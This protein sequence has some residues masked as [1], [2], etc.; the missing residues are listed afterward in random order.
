MNNFSI[1]GSR[2]FKYGSMSVAITALVIAAVVILNVIFSILASANGWFIDLTTESLY[3]LSDT[4]VELLGKTFDNINDERKAEGAEP[5]KV[6]IRFCDLE[7]NIMA[8]TAQRY[9]LITAKQLAEKFPDVIEIEYINI[10]ENPTA[11]EKYKTSVLTKIYS[12]H[13]IV[14]SGSEYRAYD[15]TSFYLTNSGSTTPFA[16]MGEKR[17]TSG[18]LAVTQAECPVAAVL[19]G[20]G[21]I[22]TDT[23]LIET[24]DMAG[25]EVI[26]VNDLVKEELPD[27]CRLMVCYNPTADFVDSNGISDISEISVLESFLAD[28]NHT[29]MVYMSPT[30]PKLPVLESYLELWGVSFMRE[31]TSANRFASYTVKDSN[32]ALTGDGLTFIAE[33]ETLGLGG[34]VTKDLRSSSVPR[35]IIFK[36]SMPIAIADEFE[37]LHD[38]DADTGATIK[39][40]LKNLGSGY[41]RETYFLFSASD[42]AVA[43]A[44][45]KE[46]VKADSNNKLGLMTITRQSRYVQEDRYGISVA[47]QSS[48]VIACGST[49]FVSAALLK[50]N[51][52]GNSELLMKL[53]YETGKE[54]IPSDIPITLFA[55]TTIDTLTVKRANAYT[56]VLTVVPTAIVF[57]LGIFVIV[58]RK[59]S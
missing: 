46:A 14:E 27:N 3:T 23:A 32:K 44:D 30:S 16:Y 55:D 39:Y 35:K 41:S 59:H 20:H 2:R 10:W 49:E 38:T 33:Y 47:D 31:E 40:G 4:S 43:M 58:R 25:Y 57:G 1:F 22:F 15:Q 7:D 11:V 17:L 42:K 56:L 53:F 6:R 54:N 52:Y 13:V 45:G 48:Y 50:S 9:V 24:L 29:F 8:S 36:N 28:N 5:L 12:T 51:T 34:S 37:I 26:T 21:E 18:I 19:T